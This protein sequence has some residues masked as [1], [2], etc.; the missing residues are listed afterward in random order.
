MC[1]KRALKSVSESANQL[2]CVVFHV[3][4][5][6]LSLRQALTFCRAASWSLT[7]SPSCFRTGR[8]W[9]YRLSSFLFHPL[10]LTSYL[11]SCPLSPPSSLSSFSV[12]S[13]SILL[14]A[15]LFISHPLFIHFCILL[16]FSLIP[17]SRR[18]LS[19][20]QSPLTPSGYYPAH[21]A[22]LFRPRP[23]YQTGGISL[24]LS[25]TCAA[26]WPAGRKQP[27]WMCFPGSQPPRSA[28]VRARN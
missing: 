20:P 27:G 15:S 24:F 11:L 3:L 13:S 6:T 12:L 19:S 17:H 2:H 28:Y 9:G 14:S 10:F 25:G 4:S 18:P 23:G 26:G 7:R 22:S 8:S 16:S 5:Q 21:P 1:S